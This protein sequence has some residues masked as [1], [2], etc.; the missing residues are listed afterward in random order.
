ME[1]LRDTLVVLGVM[2]DKLL[3]LLAKL[4]YR[5]EQASEK[6]PLSVLLDTKV[7]DLLLIAASSVPEYLDIIEHLR[8]NEATRRIPVVLTDLAPKDVPAVTERKFE[9]IEVVPQGS[10]VASVSA[11]V[12]TLLRLRKMAGAD[13]ANASVAEM[14]AMLRDLNTRFQ[15]EL[16]EAQKIQQ[17]LLPPSLPRGERFELAVTY[18]PLDGVGGDWYFARAVERG[19]LSIQIADVTGHGLSAAFVCSMTKLALMAVAKAGAYRVNADE[20][21]ERPD[22][23][24]G[25][26]NS[27]L[28]P[29]LSD[30]RFV[31]AASLRYDPSSGALEC[32]RAGHPPPLIIRHE[33]KAGV[34]LKARGFALGF[35]D[36][37]QYELVAETLAVGDLLVLYTDGITEAQNRSLELYGTER[38]I[39]SLAAEGSAEQV[40][41]GLLKD[42]AV[43]TEGRLL[44]DDVTVVVLK[45]TA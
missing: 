34:E 44:K 38:L 20:E 3:R 7:V 6:L 2:D 36:E 40:L 5:L 14:N 27:L 23:L 12:A 37:A 13:S 33:S 41:E 10:S 4:G 45:R 22:I 24:L 9:R 35:M 21:V 15:K 18:R 19:C 43:F 39:R 28:A 26:M 11:K 1:E 31:T 30:E 8:G 32:A 42:F 17:G 29:Q 25:R 16:E